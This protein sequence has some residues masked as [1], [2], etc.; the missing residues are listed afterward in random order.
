[1]EK[2][3]VLRHKLSQEIQA[4]LTSKCE[5]PKAVRGMEEKGSLAF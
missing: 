1:M 4:I 2:D 5:L 3:G